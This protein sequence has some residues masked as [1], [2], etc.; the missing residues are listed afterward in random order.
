MQP[1]ATRGLDPPYPSADLEILQL[2]CDQR[3]QIV[4][5]PSDKD[6]LV[7]IDAV[8]AVRPDAT[9]FGLAFA[10]EKARVG[11]AAPGAQQLA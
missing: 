1:Q 4:A 8:L 3:R 7:D 9:I 5:A 2:L 10:T 11:W 6:G